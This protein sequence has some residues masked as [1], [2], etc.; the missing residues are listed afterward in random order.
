MSGDNLEVF[1]NNEIDI[2]IATGKGKK[3]D[4]RSI[5]DSNRKIKKADFIYDEDKDCFI[6]PAGRILELKSESGDGKTIDK[7]DKAG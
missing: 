5:E 2:Y 4:Q 3:K 7:A 6:C 1:E